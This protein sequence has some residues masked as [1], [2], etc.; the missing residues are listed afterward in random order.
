[1]VTAYSLLSVSAVSF[2]GSKFRDYF[3]LA[4]ILAQKNGEPDMK[5]ARF[6]D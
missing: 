4:Q 5:Y 6:S 1:M 3:P 2:V